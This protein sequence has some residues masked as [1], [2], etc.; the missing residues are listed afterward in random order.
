MKEAFAAFI[1]EQ[2]KDAYLVAADKGLET[3]E[4]LGMKPDL[5]VGDFDSSSAELAR[6]YERDGCELQVFNP[7]KDDTDT[8]IA[9]R[10]CIERGY[11]EILLLGGTG[12]RLDH[13]LGNL[14]LL[15]LS[16]RLGAELI[17]LD[18]NNRIRLLEAN[19]TYLLRKEEAFGDYVSLV[20]FG[21]AV[22]GLTLHGMKYSLDK[23]RMSGENSLGISNEIT[24][25]EAEISFEKG[26]LLLM[27]S[28]D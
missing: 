18:S 16:H 27:E 23:A 6:K 24:D 3:M 10:A 7:V 22:E 21:G 17:L 13:V 12:T 25:T 15:A 26:R 4:R 14:S 28:R 11:K 2:N 9:V 5:I 20:P 19:Q 1:W 8:E